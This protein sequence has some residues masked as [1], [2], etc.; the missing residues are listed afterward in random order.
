M[1]K[2]RMTAIIA[3]LLAT[4]FVLGACSG[5]GSAQTA[6]TPA[7]SA[8]TK[9]EAPAA[10]AETKSEAPAE[11]A[12]PVASEGP[13]ELTIGTYMAITTLEPWKTTSDGDGYVIRQIYHT[14][15]EMNKKSEFTPSLAK[16]WECSDDGLVWTVNLRD[17]VYWHTGNGLFAEGEKVQVT[18]ED[19]K[20][21][22]DYYLDPE[23]GSVRYTELSKT[24][25]KVE[26]V[27]DFTVKF[28]TKNV[29]VLWEYRMYQNYIIPKKGV[30]QN[31][32]WHAS[33]VGSGA[34]KFV[35]HVI[36]TQVVLEK[37]ED[38]WMEPGLDKITYKIIPDRSV[39][40][41]ALQN[42]EIDIA[43]AVLPTEVGHIAEKD[44]LTLTDS[45]TGSLRW[46][47]FNC[48]W[49]FFQDVNVRRAI[50]MGVDLNS[51]VEA[52]FKNDAGAKLAVRAWSAIPLER[53][54][55]NAEER[56]KAAGMHYDPEKAQALLEENG[57]A[58]GSDGIYAKDGKRLSFQLQV[59]NNDANREKLAVIV[60]SQ[61]QAI[62]IECVAHTAEWGTHTSDIKDGNTQMFILG[63]YSNLDG[64]WRLMGYNETT[65]S[66]N[67]GYKNEDVEAILAEAN[68][69]TD[70]DER[71]ELLT[72]ASEIYVSEAPVMPVYF[73]YTQVGF[74][75]RVTDFDYATVYQ[76]L[77]GTER[78]VSV[79]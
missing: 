14:L 21:S 43:L 74:N 10:S 79:Q 62:G 20:F 65:M 77:C 59:G 4:M 5:G 55:G 17:D 76:A 40:A 2:T 31:W 1:K 24:L 73:E 72:R 39:S 33:P 22:Y 70:F 49:D 8:E 32:D 18:A 25:D 60:S 54:G 51:A 75:N 48:T 53:P 42:Q 11:S 67:S 34:Y 71:S 7:A 69:T 6:Q 57:W 66:P 41:I 46:I 26:V 23:T 12:A 44:Y 36:D 29:D 19:V 3:A 52:I 47:G 64:P 56:F 63:G 13:K 16:S 45:G 50:A 78:N 61:L 28:Y 38:F 27:D 37:N 58:K 9:S 15:V 30:E 68:K 35:E